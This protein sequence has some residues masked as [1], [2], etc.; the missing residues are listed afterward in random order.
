[1]RHGLVVLWVIA[2]C[3]RLGFD[4]LPAAGDGSSS[5]G[6]GLT[7]YR[8]VV[9]QDGPIVYWRLGQI[10]GIANDEMGNFFASF[11]GACTPTTGPLRD[12]LDTA[13]HFDGASCF[14]IIPSGLE[15]PG[16][17]P[18][19]VEMWVRDE[20]VNQYQ[21]YFIKETRSGGNP[22]DG[23]ALLINDTTGVYLER[24]VNQTGQVTDPMPI[25]ANQWV[26][27]VATYDGVV[28]AM[29]FN[30]AQVGPSK[31]A[32]EVMPAVPMESSIAAFPA[33]NT[34]LRGDLDEIAI[35]D[36]ALSSER[37]AKHHDI[38]INGPISGN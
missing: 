20:L 7:T 36:H 10:A 19:S 26:H 34:F 16:N 12:D 37:I 28:V 21:M 5:D 23:Y 30:G 29:Y 8:D 11:Q 17:A 18:F 32:P 22:M 33:G 24:I 27:I 25:P 3:G 14:A 35:Y 4:P 1:V 13:L 2:G 9:V 15:F 38:A 31:T 6:D